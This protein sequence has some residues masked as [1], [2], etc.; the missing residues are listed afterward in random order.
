MADE[1]LDIIVRLRD[2]SKAGSDSVKKNIKGIGDVAKHSTNLI[3][4]MA[5]SLIGIASV[6]GTGFVL[7]AGFLN[8]LR[9]FTEFDDI[10]LQVGAVTSATAE[11]MEELTAIAKEMGETTRFSASEAAEGL[12]LLGMAGFNAAEAIKALPGVLNLAAAGSLDLA[13]AADITTNVLA[14]FGL[15]IDKLGRVND[16][17]VKTFTSSNNNLRELGE[18]FSY[19][20]P[21]A[22]GV[23]ADFEDLLAAIGKLGDAGLKASLGGTTLRGTLQALFNPTKQE[24]K[25]MDELSQRIG[26]AGFQIKDAEGNFIGF[27]DIIKQL[28]KAG[29]RGEEALKLFGLRAGPGVA[30][31]LNQ[32]S[33][34]LEQLRDDLRNAGGTADRIASEME[35]KIGGATRELKA[36][37]EGLQIAFIDA[38][39][40]EIIEGIDSTKESIQDLSTVIEENQYILQ[41]WGDIA[42]EVFNGVKALVGATGKAFLGLG[43]A[44][45]LV[46]YLIDPV[47]KTFEQMGSVI[48]DAM[49]EIIAD[50]TGIGAIEIPVEIRVEKA[51]DKFFKELE[52]DTG[53]IGTGGG[54]DDDDDDDDDKDIERL[55]AIQRA[56]FKASII[57]AKAYLDEQSALLER[58]YHDDIINVDEYFNQRE[59]ILKQQY[60][61]EIELLKEREKNEQDEA[62]RE[63]LYGIIIAKEKELQTEII[64]LHQK[65]GD[66]IDRINKEVIDSLTKVEKEQEK[67]LEKEKQATELLNDLKIQNA[68]DLATTI[69][70]QQAAEL[71]QF[72]SKQDKELAAFEKLT[73]DKAKIAEFARQQE[74]EKEQFLSDQKKALKQKELEQAQMIFSEFSN[75]TNSLFEL[76]GESSKELF[77]LKQGAAI[78]EATISAYVSANKALELGPIAGPVMA[79]IITAQALANVAQIASQ[80]FAEGGLIQGHSPHKKADNIVINATAKEFVQP[81]DSVN[82]FGVDFMTAVQKQAPTETIMALLAKRKSG[83]PHFSVPSSNS[84]KR[85][86][87]DGG[88][89]STTT[90]NIKEIQRQQTP[91]NIVNVPDPRMLSQYLNTAEGK[92]AIINVISSQAKIVRQVLT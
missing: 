21:I 91:V 78:A 1:R 36:A 6:F 5:T 87:A 81:V 56:K 28:E 61:K 37:L 51:L 18:A 16:V 62:K 92:N 68:L 83:I 76:S 33:E 47:P 10:M 63:L 8:A 2:S 42:V 50:L 90:N 84:A 12:K 75:L 57:I 58:A 60:A 48:K 59:M 41:F 73:Q 26:G 32:G 19:V 29:L 22:K 45:G 52:E 17:L 34:A 7:G 9:I 72:K 13:T 86:F 53:P 88:M 49:K 74:L 65:R 35:S 27:V 30:A 89:V 11:E 80:S 55:K 82:D 85:N 44:V 43:K 4:G 64:K 67:L 46:L 25:L 15:E 40:E 77:A 38:F 79:A 70:E 31:L 14:G 71:D 3:K 23:G 54:D 66:E 20:G 39:D 69:E 24:A